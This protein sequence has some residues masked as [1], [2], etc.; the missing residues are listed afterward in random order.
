[1]KKIAIALAVV[2]VA[3]IGVTGALVGFLLLPSSLG[4]DNI[5]AGEHAQDVFLNTSHEM[6]YGVENVNYQ[7][8]INQILTRNF[9][10]FDEALHYAIDQDRAAILQSSSRTWVWDNY[11]LFNA[12]V[13]GRFIEFEEFYQ[14]A[15]Y[16]RRHRNAYVINRPN[17]AIAWSNSR[18]LERSVMLDVPNILQFPRLPRGCEVTSLAILLNFAGIDVDKMTLA[19]QVRQNPVEREVRNGVIYGGHPNYGFV[20]DMFNSANHGLGV[21]HAPIFELMQKYLPDASINLTGS[22]FNDLLVFINRGVPVWVITNATYNYLG[23]ENF[24]TW[25]T[26]QGEIQITYWLHAVVIS[27]YDENY[28]YFSNPLADRPGIASRTRA[29][30]HEFIAAW[31]QMG[32]QAISYAF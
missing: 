8:Y 19:H 3:L 2:L 10:N 21:Y 28:I 5:L 11:P 29:P 32:R 4:G 16:A 24:D 14:A 27:G 30:R 1:M 17:Q 13:D 22:E 15:N 12:V 25:V 9:D 20:G 7:V 26:P 31:E 23:P 6:L 18:P